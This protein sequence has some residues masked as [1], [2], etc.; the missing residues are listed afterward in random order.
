MINSVIYRFKEE[1]FPS[2]PVE[3]HIDEPLQQRLDLS[4]EP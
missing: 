2:Q 4:S 3:L 1:D